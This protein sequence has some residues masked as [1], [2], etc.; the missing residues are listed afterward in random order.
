MDDS[1][2]PSLHPGLMTDALY[3]LLHVRALSIG[4]LDIT[5]DSDDEHIDCEVQFSSGPDVG[6][7]FDTRRGTYACCELVGDD[8]ERWIEAAGGQADLCT[9]ADPAELAAQLLDALLAARRGITR[10]EW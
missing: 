4:A 1:N 7:T 5:V 8:E 6:L 2:A 3:E 9:H 10:G